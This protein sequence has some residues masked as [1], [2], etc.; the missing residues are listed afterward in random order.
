M[1]NNEIRLL[2]VLLRQTVVLLLAD[3]FGLGQIV[4]QGVAGVEEAEQIVLVS[5]LLLR[6]P[7]AWLNLLN[8]PTPI[9]KGFTMALWF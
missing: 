6:G 5:L 7:L 2:L 3:H 1:F 8:K 4:P 9:Q